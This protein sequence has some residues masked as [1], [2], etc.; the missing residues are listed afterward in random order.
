MDH[1]SKKELITI[2]NKQKEDLI[3][4]KNRLS[5][6][7]NDFYTSICFQLIFLNYYVLFIIMT[8]C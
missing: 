6:I 1:A 3:R 2:V 5:G 4:Y 8:E 7:I